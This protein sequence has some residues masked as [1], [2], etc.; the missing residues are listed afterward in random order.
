MGSH[1]HEGDFEWDALNQVAMALIVINYILFVPLL[2]Y[3]AWKFYSMRKERHFAKRRP[4]IV[5][6][7]VTLCILHLSS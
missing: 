6:L 5:L 3:Y 7:F 4:K 1:S 2:V